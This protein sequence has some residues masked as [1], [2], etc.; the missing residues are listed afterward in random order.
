MIRFQQSDDPKSVAPTTY[1]QF[2]QRQPAAGQT[3][4]LVPSEQGGVIYLTPVR[5]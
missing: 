5:G 2:L 4:T 1:K 3:V